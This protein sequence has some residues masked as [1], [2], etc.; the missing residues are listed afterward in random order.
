MQAWEPA[1]KALPS[2][3]FV[4]GSKDQTLRVW[5]ANTRRCIFTMSSHTMIVTCVRWGGEGLIY[6]S[7][8]DC[9]INVW[10]AAEGKLVR[11]LKGHAH[12]VNTLALSTE[13]VLRSGAFDHT[14]KAPADPQEA[15][16][17]RW[18][19]AHT[20]GQLAVQPWTCSASPVLSRGAGSPSCNVLSRGAWCCRPAGCAS[21]MACSWRRKRPVCLS[22]RLL[23]RW[24]C[25]PAGGAA[26]V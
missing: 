5:D 1:H 3:R 6:S 11:T 17:V 15:M 18:V 19:H 2:R 20:L 13:A 4:S 12:W 10:S 23:L 24:L 26:A 8:R 9:C 25:V 16:Q 14:G 22:D 7:S 21:C